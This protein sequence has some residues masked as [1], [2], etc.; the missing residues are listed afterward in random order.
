MLIF[1]GSLKLNWMFY[2]LFNLASSI[3]S[4]GQYLLPWSKGRP[5]THLWFTSVILIQ[6]VFIQKN[7]EQCS[8]LLPV[9]E[10]VGRV[11][12]QAVYFPIRTLYLTLKIEQRERYK[13]GMSRAGPAGQ[14]VRACSTG[15]SHP[16]RCGHTPAPQRTS[17]HVGQPLASERE[18]L[19]GPEG[20][21]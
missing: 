15:L 8:S 2:L 20:R 18:N 17:W 12:P 9:S 13:S 21:A 6:S 14:A 7:S 1:L 4:V 10:Q 3:R 11:Y 5:A 16:V 19:L